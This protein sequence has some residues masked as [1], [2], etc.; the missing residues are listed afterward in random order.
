M[1][2]DQGSLVGLVSNRDLRSYLLPRAEQIVRAADA[3]ARLQAN[4]ESVMRT[5]MLTV[6]P[7]TTVAA[8]I[9]L[10]LREQVGAVLVPQPTSRTLLG[11]VSYID[12]LRVAP[13]LF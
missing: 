7:Q 1:V 3:Q 2:V 13:A 11:I 8:M 6:T 9:D 4:V 12:V 5:D 10:F